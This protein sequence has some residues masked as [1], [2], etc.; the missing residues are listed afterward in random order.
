[1]TENE[2][3]LKAQKG[4]SECLE[5]LINKYEAYMKKIIRAS[6]ITGNYTCEDLLSSAVIGF[7]GSLKNFDVSRG[8][9]IMAFSKRRM[10]GAVLSF[11][12]K[13]GCRSKV[14]YK[15]REG[16]IVKEF[17]LTSL[18]DL[19]S[20]N[21]G[22]STSGIIS[23]DKELESVENRDFVS[24]ILDMLTSKESD[25]ITQIYF[26]DKSVKDISLEMNRDK[27]GI[28]RHRREIFSKIREGVSAGW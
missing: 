9:G 15:N 4:D 27:S 26:E 12:S 17:T 16:S 28:H 21:D 5:K 11:L 23:F 25:L 14:V 7:I 3:I 20:K 22:S 24:N 13:D 18:D 1:M 10:L 2:L 8:I 19:L 6:I